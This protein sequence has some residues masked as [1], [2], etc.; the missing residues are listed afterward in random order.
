MKWEDLKI[1][2]L[3]KMF[4]LDSKELV[5][6][7]NTNVYL[8]KMPAAAN[9]AMLL[10]VTAGRRFRKLAEIYQTEGEE[11]TSPSFSLGT[12]N[13]YDLKDITTDYYAMYDGEI[14]WDN[15]ESYEPYMNY[16]M[17]GNGILLLP[18]DAK[19]L[20]RI[21]Y[22][23]YPPKLTNDTANSFEIDIYPEE[24]NMVALYMAGELYKE[25]DAQL[26]QIYMNEFSAWLEELKMSGNR[27]NV[28]RNGSGKWVSEKGWY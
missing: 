4:E 15:G 6:D 13:G 14:L 26:A 10:L 22:D 23:A 2:C 28:N 27:A 8:S 11:K 20:F 5:E 24:A 18:Q 7:E 9:E 16:R 3:H 12:Y 19:G 1:T 17:E 25:D 21:W